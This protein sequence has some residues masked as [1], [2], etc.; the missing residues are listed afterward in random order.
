MTEQACPS[1]FNF[2]VAMTLTLSTLLTAFISNMLC[3][4]RSPL[5]LSGRRDILGSFLWEYRECSWS[6]RGSQGYGRVTYYRHAGYFRAAVG[7]HTAARCHNARQAS[8][9]HSNTLHRCCIQYR[10]LSSPTI[11]LPSKL[12]VAC[13]DVL[14]HAHEAVLPSIRK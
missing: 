14:K 9:S 11:Q 3:P 6:I 4:S 2:Y 8:D 7:T 12:D 5:L 13:G 10:P 1:C